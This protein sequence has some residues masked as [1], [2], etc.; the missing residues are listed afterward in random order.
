MTFE[1]SDF[2]V[3]E[4]KGVIADSFGNKTLDAKVEL[5]APC[6]LCGEKHVYLASE[7]ACPFEIPRG[8]SASKKGNH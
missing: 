1:S 2:N 6:P 3:I 4:N 8:G 7:L 5:N